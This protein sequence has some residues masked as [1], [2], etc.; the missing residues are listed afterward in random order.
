M[1]RGL[2]ALL[3]VVTLVISGGSSAL[4]SWAVTSA[5]VGGQTPVAGIDGSDGVDGS[6]GADG[7]EGAPGAAG[8]QG[9]TGAPGAPGR[10]GA[11]GSQGPQGPQG[12][13]GSPGA[14]GADALLAS[15]EMTAPDGPRSYVFP[16]LVIGTP[17]EVEAAPLVLIAW[18]A[19]LQM[20]HTA[21]AVQ[22]D[23]RDSVANRWYAG[24]S[25]YVT[26]SSPVTLTGSAVVNLSAGDAV[27]E[28][29]C[30][31]LWNGVSQTWTVT[32]AKVL[33]ATVAT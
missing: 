9:S 4:V 8:P 30:Q 13:P 1:S 23:V 6:D 24:A 22:C 19:T 27:L 33:V 20:E 11:A 3:L 7:S 21:T 25:D 2:V 15:A 14:D 31:D 16:L 17:I 32:D 5:V 28:L 26:T 12:L 29:V 10:N 18:Q